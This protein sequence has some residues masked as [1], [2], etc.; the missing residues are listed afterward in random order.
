[1]RIL[2]DG[3]DLTGKSTLVRELTPATG[4]FNRCAFCSQ[5]AGRDVWQFTE[6][7]LTD[8][9]RTCAAVAAE[10]GLRIAGGRIH[11]RGVLFPYL[12]NDIASYPHLDTLCGLARDVLG[13]R[14]RVSTIGYSSLNPHLT[15]MNERIAEQYGDVFDG[16]RLS[17]TP[18]TISW[19][20]RDPDTSRAQFVR[21]FANALT[22]YRPVFDQLGH[23]RPRPPWR[24]A[25]PHCS[26]QLT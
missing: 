1:M 25:S 16:I 10:R 19:T 13:V 14:L 3:L 12:D 5:Q 26:I 11:R 15:A 17:L 23:G 24:C 9:T 7:G 18:H 21:D 8:F 2:I 20:G 4:C 22:T 6:R